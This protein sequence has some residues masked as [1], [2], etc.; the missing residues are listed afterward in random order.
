M[1][2]KRKYSKGTLGEFG[3]PAKEVELYGKP[4]DYEKLID[5]LVDQV[6]QDV[7]DGQ[8]PITKALSSSSSG[9]PNKAIR[10][11][12]DKI[13][14]Y[15]G[16]Q[17]T[18]LRNIVNEG[19]ANLINLQQEL[20]Y[21]FRKLNVID[22]KL[23]G[24]VD[25]SNGTVTYDLSGDT[26]FSDITNTQSLKYVLLDRVPDFLERL[27]TF[28][29]GSKI[30]NKAAF[31]TTTFTISDPFTGVFITNEENRFYVCNSTIFLNEGSYQDFLNSLTSLEEV[32]KTDGMGD[33]IKEICDEIKSD[34]KEEYDAEVRNF[35]IVKTDPEYVSLSTLELPVIPAKIG[36]ISPATTDVEAKQTRLKNL[37]ANR[38][39]NTTDTFDGKV[40]LN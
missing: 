35:D 24:Y 13:K 37:Y 33:K 7:G 6:L 9:Y 40:T 32:K 21:T 28:M 26:F 10:E 39:L 34:Y 20:I 27:N 29:F 30:D 2:N 19:F 25:A 12:K 14:F 18:Q 23:D 11:V 15:V 22:S 3:G 16:G 36:F 1:N 38:N 5:G 4:Y 17:K 8:D 31:D